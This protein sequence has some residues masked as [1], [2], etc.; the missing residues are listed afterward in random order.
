M[1]MKMEMIEWVDSGYSLLGN[2]WQDRG[3]I[4]ELMFCQ[5]HVKTVGFTYR[6]NDNWVVLVQSVDEKTDQIRGGFM[7]Y[8]QNIIS[9]KDVK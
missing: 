6:E 1:L 9:R 8:K 5:N 3:D 2:V 4:D 7:I